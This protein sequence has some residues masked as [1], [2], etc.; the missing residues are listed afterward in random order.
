MNCDELRQSRLDAAGEQGR[1][2]LDRG[3]RAL[4]SVCGRVVARGSSVGLVRAGDAREY[5]VLAQAGDVLV[6]V[7]R[8]SGGGA[9]GVECV[10]SDL[11]GGGVGP[12]PVG[13]EEHPSMG[14][15]VRSCGRR[16]QRRVGLAVDVP[17]R[18]ALRVL[19]TER[20]RAAFQDAPK[21]YVRDS[22]V[23]LGHGSQRE[24]DCEGVP[25]GN[26]VI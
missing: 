5:S 21:R 15:R 11:L 20:V 3:R 25:V 22:G 23:R 4:D 8:V 10:L 7:E 16:H 26:N 14:G 17:G 24:L 19:A 13:L 6:R 1:V 2:Q 12:P 9:G 18:Y